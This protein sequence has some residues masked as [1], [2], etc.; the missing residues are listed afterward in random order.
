MFLFNKKTRN[1]IKY[2]WGFFAILI[3]LSMV[4]A[5]SGFATL[6]QTPSSTETVEI[7]AEVRE[8]LLNGENTNATVEEQKIIDAIKSGEIEIG[9]DIPDN[10]T[11]TIENTEEKIPETPP[12]PELK[13]EI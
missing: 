6:V 1:V 7:P 8:Q 12:V 13:L 5:Y 10:T 9:T 2:I 11:K 3:I 4:I